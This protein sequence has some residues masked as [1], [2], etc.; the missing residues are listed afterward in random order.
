MG[1]TRCSSFLFPREIARPRFYLSISVHTAIT[2][3]FFHIFYSPQ[4]LC[5]FLIHITPK[6]AIQE[7]K[8]SVFLIKLKLNILPKSNS[9]SFIK[10]WKSVSADI[11]NNS[12]E[13]TFL[14]PTVESFRQADKDWVQ[15]CK[16]RELTLCCSQH[17]M[18][19]MD[20]VDFSC[21]PATS[22][23]SN[24]SQDPTPW[25]RSSTAQCT[26]LRYKLFQ[27]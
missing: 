21:S 18:K 4:H 22:R 9:S 20:R 17:R 10:L 12:S 11:Q 24:T 5:Y 15:C 6:N 8:G 14:Q 25:D 7:H 19:E 1:P 13:L 3:V 2:S 26:Q 27:F 23:K 16:V